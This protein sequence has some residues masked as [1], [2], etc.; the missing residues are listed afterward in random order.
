[1]DKIA[2]KLINIS[3]DDK[4]KVGK[5][6][7]IPYE[8]ELK[9]DYESF[10]KFITELEKHSRLINIDE[11]RLFNKIEKASSKK[12]RKALLENRVEMRISTITLNKTK[13]K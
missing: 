2:I 1:M 13:S 6:T 12:N 11:F 4:E 8:I 10:G 3:P 5:Y 7:Y 9:C